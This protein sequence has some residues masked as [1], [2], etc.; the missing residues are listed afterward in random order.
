MTLLRLAGIGTE[1]RPDFVQVQWRN[2]RRTFTAIS[3]TRA[4]DAVGDAHDYGRRLWRPAKCG[5]N[6]VVLAP[7]LRAR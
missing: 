2:P 4:R 6:E 1:S 5:S 3:T 7:P